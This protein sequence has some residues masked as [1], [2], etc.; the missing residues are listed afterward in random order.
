MN[1]PTFIEIPT[2]RYGHTIWVN[3]SQ[4]QAVADVDDD[5][6]AEIIVSGDHINTSLYVDDLV[7]MLRICGCRLLTRGD[8][9]LIGE[10]GVE[11]IK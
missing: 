11:G 9:D 7:R 2:L 3:T 8:I 10:P 1:K 4:I 5:G 6:Y